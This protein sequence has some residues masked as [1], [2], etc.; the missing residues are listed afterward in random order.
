MSIIADLT[1]LTS[2]IFKIG[3]FFMS[4]RNYDNT[5]TNHRKNLSSPLVR[6]SNLKIINILGREILKSGSGRKT[7]SKT[8]QPE[9]GVAARWELSWVVLMTNLGSGLGFFG[10]FIPGIEVFLENRYNDKES[11][12]LMTYLFR[13]IRLHL[14]IRIRD[15]YPG[16]WDFFG[17][18]LFSLWNEI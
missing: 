14:F 2:D 1:R 10:I 12:L 6:K 8:H 13:L 3:Q 17:I 9:I 11:V 4:N 15:F 16:I 7:L 18:A 5:Q